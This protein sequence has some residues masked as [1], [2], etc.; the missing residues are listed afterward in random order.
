LIEHTT[1][2][3]FYQLEPSMVCKDQT[4]NII[5]L[6]FYPDIINQL[7]FQGAIVNNHDRLF[8]QNYYSWCP[9]INPDKLI[10]YRE[11]YWLE[12]NDLQPDYMVIAPGCIDGNPWSVNNLWNQ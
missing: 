3:Q 6:L 7:R 10:N 1:S 8:E 11:Y 9:P 4:G 12:V 2:R 5:S